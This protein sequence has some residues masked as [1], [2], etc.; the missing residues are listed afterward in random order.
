MQLIIPRSLPRIIQTHIHIMKHTYTSYRHTYTCYKQTYTIIQTHIHIIQ[1]HVHIIQTHPIHHT[2]THTHHT[3][4]RTHHT[5]THT[6]E[7][8]HILYR[9][10][11]THNNAQVAVAHAKVAP[12]KPSL[13][14]NN[15]MYGH[16]AEAI[17]TQKHGALPAEPKGN[18]LKGAAPPVSRLAAP[19]TAYGASLQVLVH[20]NAY[21]MCEN[22]YLCG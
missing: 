16:L 20:I 22:V 21:F 7:Q 14:Q 3:N 12:K 17:L 11:Y 15:G 9:H 5:D 4:K 10:T 18:I 19:T 13:V 8:R 2:D 1:T 6:H